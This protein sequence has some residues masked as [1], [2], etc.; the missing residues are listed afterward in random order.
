MNLVEKINVDRLV[1]MKARE[2]EKLSTLR[3]LST[4]LKNAEIAKKGELT[5][6]EAQQILRTEK[7]KR[8]EAV[9]AFTKGGKLDLAEQEKREFELITTYLPQAMS[10]EELA[11]L[12]KTVLSENNIT[13]ISQFGQAMGLVVKATAGRAE[14]N[15][16]QAKVKELL[17]S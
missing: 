4:A 17:G 11:T 6:V 14:G 10:A 7:K 15:E 12:V 3:M 8:Q 16:I 5:E 2:A 13:E 1:A 9:E